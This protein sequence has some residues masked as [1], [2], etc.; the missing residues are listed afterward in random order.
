[1][2]FRN[3]ISMGHRRY[4]V[5]IALLA[6]AAARA[7]PKDPPIVPPPMA[8][9]QSLSVFR[10]RSIDVPLRAQGRAPG[11]LKFLIRSLPV[12]GHL[13]EIRLTGPKSAEITY[14]H[15]DTSEG[16]D[17]FTFAVQ[18]FDSPVSAAA[19]ITISIAE[20]P[21][22]LTVTKSV[23]FGTLE[24]GTTGEEQIVV[25][26]SGGGILEGVAE[27]SP[28]WK[29]SGSAEYRLGRNQIKK[30]RVICAPEE[31]QD[32]SGRL[33]FSHDARAA[34][35]LTASAISP[36]D[37]DPAREIE[38]AS[39]DAGALR[40]GGVAIRN[41]TG[42]DRT[43]EIAV[44]PEIVSPNKVFIPA[45][46][47]VG[48]ALHTRPGF[49]GALEGAV[50]F[51]SEGF[52]RSIPVRIFALQPILR[53]EPREG[54]HF[55]QIEPR[56]RHK[57][58]LR[59]KNE[60][61]SAARL[62]VRVPG[63]IL[64]V[65]D[66]NSAVLQ[67]GETRV[68][69]VAFEAPSAGDYRS[70]IVIESS[71]GRPASVPIEARIGSQPAEAQKIPTAAL[72]PAARQAATTPESRE[73]SSSVPAVK[74]IKVLKAGNRVFEI[75]WNKPA[76]DPL[77]WIVQQRH[78]E[79]TDGDAPK[80]IWRDLTNVRF[81]EQN[82][83]IGARF[84]NLAPGQ[85]WFLRIVSLDQ[86]G[87]RSAPSPTFMMSSAPTKDHTLLRGTLLLL[88]VA[89]GVVGFLKFRQRRQAEASEQAEQ[90]ARIERR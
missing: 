75:G 10:G 85:V 16:T 30:L 63:E 25:Q 49:L 53:I 80:A 36:F 48:I 38:L 37:F 31:E 47:E 62:R 29:I 73:P 5:L 6:V 34:V 57:G 9:P 70:E 82:D 52:K 51:Q 2:I 11:Q 24:V 71:A 65:P 8:Q 39:Q 45:D 55:G 83:T 40:S 41:R 7:G 89:A 64:L 74:E 1:M 60:G 22:A 19:P 4:L 84:E 79:A 13:G 78:V 67:P 50:T 58:F 18:T 44:P 23:D 54:L 66:P 32:Y 42:R 72:K 46:E 56:R 12:K 86:Q 27:V 77:A 81:F 3:E 68:F 20:E 61:G 28:P 14:F 59:I 69:E 90:I 33:V 87:R 15:D 26:N 43:V 88:A 76:S 21:P 35:E 17:S